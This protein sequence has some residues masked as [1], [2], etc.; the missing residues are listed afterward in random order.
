MARQH[1]GREVWDRACDAVR[2]PDGLPTYMCGAWTIEKLFFVCQYLA[3]T[4]QAMVGNPRFTA[5]NY[6]DLFCGNGVCEVDDRSG[7]TR[8]YPGS[9]LLASL[10]SKPFTNLFLV[11]SDKRNID[12]VTTRLAQ[13]KAPMNIRTWVGDANVLVDEVA[14]AIPARSLTIAFIDPYSL[15]MR[16]ESVRRLAQQRPVDLLILFADAMDIV[17]NVEAYYLPRKSDKLDTFLGTEAWRTDWAS[18]A[19]RDG[20][21]TRE[22][23]AKVYLRQLQNLGYIYARTRVIRGEDGPLYRLVYASKNALGLKFWDIA[24]SEDL[25]G[26]KG[27]FAP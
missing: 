9:A 25:H 17:R 19:N 11:D 14:T 12:A 27:L 21:S 20:P 4:T 26:N 8:R 10:C 2:F 24:E 1:F 3:Q 5:I 7:S 23:F 18:L 15:D 16:F 22:M 13:V 6:V